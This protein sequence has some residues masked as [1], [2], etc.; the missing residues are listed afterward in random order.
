MSTIKMPTADSLVLRRK[1]QIVS[2]LQEALP[3]DSVIFDE[4]ET[5]AYEYDPSQRPGA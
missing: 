3:R 5:R 4:N 2:V 1:A